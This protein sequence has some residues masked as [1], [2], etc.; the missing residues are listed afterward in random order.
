MVRC[1]IESQGKIEISGQCQFNA[2][3]DG[4]FFLENPDSA[5]PLFGEI[6]QVSVTI[7]G[8]DAAEVRGLTQEGINSR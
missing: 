2:D 4:S 5:K 7:V 6:L 3:R 1:R 8:R